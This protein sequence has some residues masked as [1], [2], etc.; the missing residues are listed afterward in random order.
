MTKNLIFLILSVMIGAGAVAQQANGQL[1]VDEQIELMNQHIENQSRAISAVEKSL[2]TSREAKAGG[3]VGIGAAVLTQAAVGL[4]RAGNLPYSYTK[5]EAVFL[6]T[7][8][9]VVEINGVRTIL[10]ESA[11]I[12]DLL[13]Q[14]EVEKGILNVKIKRRDALIAQSRPQK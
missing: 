3:I 2:T 10:I 4:G 5:T 12:P 9:V 7:L 8:G 6:A 14:I 13:Q 1:S 11:K